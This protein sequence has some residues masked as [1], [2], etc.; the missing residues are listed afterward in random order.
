M[1]GMV[2]QMI[3]NDIDIRKRVLNFQSLKME[4]PLISPFFEAQLQG[5]SY[6]VTLDNEIVFI[7]PTNK[8]VDLKSRTQVNETYEKHIIGEEGIILMPHSCA[9]I[10]L[11]ETFYIPPDLTAH[12]RP[13]TRCTR[14]GL[15]VSGQHI[16]PDSVCKLNLGV[17]NMTNN[18]FCIYAGISIAQIVFEN[19]SGIP[20]RDKLYQTK[21]D[22]H[23][24]Q[25]IAFVGADFSD[26]FS[27]FINDEVE[28]LLK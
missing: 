11:K 26:E 6:D 20:S 5:A 24:A 8:V 16:N 2:D 22:S 28:K 7:K 21:T 12:I 19:M 4:K 9:L 10:T 15:F 23:Y 25:D 3:L 13:K 17:Y 18:P 14:L 27:S 1:K